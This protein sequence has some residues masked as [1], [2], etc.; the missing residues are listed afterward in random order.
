M[1]S[2]LSK[3]FKKDKK[4]I[5]IPNVVCNICGEK[6]FYGKGTVPLGFNPCLRCGEHK[7][8]RIPGIIQPWEKSE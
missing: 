5:P 4:W 6:M 2:L 1:K 8:S 7:Q 3:I